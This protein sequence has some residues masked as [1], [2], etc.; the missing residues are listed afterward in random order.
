MK[1]AGV[2]VGISQAYQALPAYLATH[3]L[4]LPWGAVKSLELPGLAN[5]LKI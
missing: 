4:L 1:Q 5:P 3:P 2:D